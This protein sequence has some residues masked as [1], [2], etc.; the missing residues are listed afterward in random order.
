LEPYPPSGFVC[1]YKSCCPHMHRISA[2]W[3]FSQYQRLERNHGKLWN[4]IDE[5]DGLLKQANKRIAKLEAEKAQ[6]EAKYQALQR[7]Q[8]K[9]AV[10]EKTSDRN[11]DKGRARGN[12]PSASKQAKRGAPV[13]HPGWSRTKP[14]HFDAIVDVPAPSVCPHCQAHDLRPSDSVV[15]H[16]QEDVEIITRPV[17][18]LYR[19]ET[20][21][22][23]RCQKEVTGTGHGETPGNHIGP[24]TK[25]TGI[26]LH[27][28]IGLSYR[29]TRQVMKELF[30]M[31][32]AVASALAFDEKATQK[33]KPLY[34]DLREKIRA[35]PHMHADETHW[36]Q[37]G[38]NHYVWY[39]GNADLALFHIDKS[40]ASTVATALLGD[41]YQGVLVTDGYQGYNA[42]NP[43]ARQS[44][45]AH[46]IRKSDAV[47]AELDNLKGKQKH[48][49]A[50]AFCEDIHQF[51]ARVCAM[52]KGTHM[53]TEA[54][55]ARLEKLLHAQLEALCATQF[56]HKTTET[57]RK[58]LIGKE[59]S[60]WFTFLRYPDV[61][62]TNNHAEQSIRHMVILRKTS[63]GT[64]SAAGSIRH[65]ILPSLLQTA[66]RQGNKPREFIQIL[67]SQET[68]AAQNALY[69]KPP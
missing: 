24:V 36:R 28:A 53:R 43:T 41:A 37:N 3:V 8:F 61:P 57:F 44:C 55:N 14:K 48:A 66:K 18:T 11:S 10:N 35:A 31:D 29:K 42:V 6:M 64:R 25:S 52:N 65:S 54:Q 49:D 68:H 27:H 7:G 26:Y 34:D 20:A 9:A 12:L 21:H 32:Y 16:W 58:R 56:T 51:F 62:P 5:L 45:L 39:A 63:F 47:A 38:Q 13:G 30:G 1:E 60:Q 69:R 15:E 67:L 40:R 17:A 50:S 22:C 59:Q 2:S 46:L 33:G 4:T 19:H 23:G